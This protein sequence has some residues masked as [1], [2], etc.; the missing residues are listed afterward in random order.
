MNMNS[1]RVEALT[2]KLFVPVCDHLAQ[3]EPSSDKCYEVL[4][5]LAAATAL[6]IIGT[7]DDKQRQAALEFFSKALNLHLSSK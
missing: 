4:N 6:I 2:M 5:A 3:G 1:A 7:A